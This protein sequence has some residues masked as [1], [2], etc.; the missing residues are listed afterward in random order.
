MLQQSIVREFVQHQADTD[1]ICQE[2][3]PILHDQPYQDN[4]RQQLAAVGQQLSNS[5][6]QQQTMQVMQLAKQLLQPC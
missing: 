5:G 3:L 6:S 2:V 1:N 4:M